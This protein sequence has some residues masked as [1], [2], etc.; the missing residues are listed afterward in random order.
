MST[1]VYRKLERAGLRATTLRASILGL[2]HKDERKHLSAEQVAAALADEFGHSTLSSVYRVLGQLHGARLLSSVTFGE[3]RVVYELGDGRPH[4]HLV[5]QSCGRVE[6]FFD[7]LIQARQQAA[8]DEKGFTLSGNSVV[9]LG[10]CADC[11][12]NRPASNRLLDSLTDP[13]DPSE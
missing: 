3:G 8:A 13:A 9:L 12:R 10:L 4:D 11:R 6:E 2:F 5:C 1:F 7:P